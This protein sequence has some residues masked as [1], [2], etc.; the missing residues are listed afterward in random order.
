MST[1]PLLANPPT[2]FPLWRQ[3]KPADVKPAM[4]T[5]LSSMDTKLTDLESSVSPTWPGLVPPYEKLGDDLERAWGQ[6][7]HL[8]SVKDSEELRT[9]HAELQPKVVE[10]GLRVAQSPA[11]YEAFVKLKESQGD[12]LTESQLRAVEKEIR[13][14]KLSGVG[15]KGEAKE[16]FNAIQQELSQLST[17][18]S[19]NLLDATKAFAEVITEK[20]GVAGLPESALDLAAQNAQKKGHE[21]ATGESGPWLFTLDGPSY[22]AVMQHAQN[23]DL[24]EKVYKA[25]LTRASSGEKDNS[26]LI[27][28]ILALKH[29]KAQLLGFHNFGEVSLSSKMATLEKATALLDDIVSKSYDSAKADLKAVQEFAAA[30]GAPEAA[31]GLKHWDMSFWAERQREALFELKDEELR[32]YFQLP[33]VLE[34]LFSLATRLFGVKIEAADG[35]SETWHD[36]VR[37]FKVEDA[38]SGA[39]VA[40]FYL[41]PYSRP[42]E[43]KGGAWM[44]D[45]QGRSSALAPEGVPYRLPI[46]H[47]V[48]NQSP[49]VGGKPSLMSHREVETLFHEFGHAL[50]HM[51]T[52]QDCSLVSGINNVEWDAVELPS[53][54]MENWTYH[55]ATLQSIAKHYETGEVLPDE[56]F[57][58]IVAARTYRAGSQM[59]RQCHFALTDLTL[60]T[61]YTP[62]GA[63][64]VFEVEKR[65]AQK[66][67]IMQPLP[68][69]R[70]LCG[71][72][73][74]FAGGYSAGYYSYM[75][76]EVLSADAFGAFEDVGLDDAAAVEKT[77]IRFRDTVLSLGGGRDPLSVFV[78]FRGREPSADA[79]LRHNGLLTA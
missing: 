54:F 29:E 22:V 73:H 1:N 20:E 59:L 33:A 75:W 41:D 58:K 15:L 44:N 53:Q 69:D 66:T 21:G 35:E 65:V 16:R 24:R 78:D 28:Q 34:G 55:K 50:Q 68:E 64:T 6:I 19:N 37:F 26:P 79:L 27:D 76:A 40:H 36:D 72:S 5:L 10:L 48:C 52:T 3:I 56:L 14:A 77:G 8:K 70:F 42:E 74:I 2:G 4:E 18:F 43:K 60:H 13:S 45:V 63:E 23:R 17:S 32:P 9:A 11:L 30:A 62:G 39:P 67:C 51:L 25:Y 12:S 47:M 57:N 31:E 7:S 71:F 38:A 49:P 46:A 61:N